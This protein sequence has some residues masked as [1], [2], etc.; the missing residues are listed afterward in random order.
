M[1][2]ARA[3]SNI[4]ASPNWSI[5]AFAGCRPARACFFQ[6]DDVMKI[7]KTLNEPNAEPVEIMKE[8]AIEYLEYRGFY[9]EGTVEEVLQAGVSL[10]L[11]TPWAFYHFES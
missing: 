9:K 1:K 6:G 3:K 2:L 11:R 7:T 5:Y 10:N 8:T 4:Y